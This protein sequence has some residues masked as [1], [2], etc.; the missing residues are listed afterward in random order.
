[1]VKYTCIIFEH[2]IMLNSNKSWHSHILKSQSQNFRKQISSFWHFETCL[3]LCQAMPNKYNFQQLLKVNLLCHQGQIFSECQQSLGTC[4]VLSLE[5]LRLL[6]F[7]AMRMNL[8]TS[9]VVPPR[10]ETHSPSSSHS[11]LKELT[12][13]YLSV[14]IFNY[15]SNGCEPGEM[16]GSHF[17]KLPVNEQLA[18]STTL[19]TG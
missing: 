1:M 6:S 7:R 11:D 19:A 13:S 15:I 12:Y 9:A 14:Q 4:R 5:Q 18:S 2:Q 17:Q 10:S 16:R 3:S 8:W